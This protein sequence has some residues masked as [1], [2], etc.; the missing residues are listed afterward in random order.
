MIVALIVSLFFA[1]S[2]KWYDRYQRVRLQQIAAG[3]AD[4]LQ[5]PAGDE[6]GRPAVVRALRAGAGA[7][8]EGR[9]PAR[10]AP[11]HRR[12]GAAPQPAAPRA[13]IRDVADR[14]LPVL[15]HR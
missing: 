11:A 9:L 7:G 2:D 13:H 10:A 3:R 12:R 8:A 5:S 4:A 15:P 1:A 14:L 6:D